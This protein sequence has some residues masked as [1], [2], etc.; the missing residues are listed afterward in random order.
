MIK[1]FFLKVFEKVFLFLLHKIIKWKYQDRP[2]FPTN[3]PFDI[4]EIFGNINKK[5]IFNQKIILPYE[6]LNFF[7]R[8][9]KNKPCEILEVDILEENRQKKIQILKGSKSV[10][11]PL[12]LINQKTTRDNEEDYVQI[13][14]GCDVQTLKLKYLNRFHY[15]PIRSNQIIN[16][17]KINSS[18]NKL[19]IGKPLIINKN[20]KSDKPKL[21]VHIFIDALTQCIIDKF[22]YKI[23]PNTKKYFNKNGTFFTNTY[24]QS[25]WT[26]SSIAGIFTGKYTNEHLIYHP[27]NKDKINNITLADVLQEEGYLTY[28]CTNIPKL[29]PINGFDKGFDRYILAAENDY[30]YIIN[31]ACEQLDTFGNYQYLFLGFFDL[32]ESHKLPPISSQTSNPLEDFQFRRLKGNSKD[33]TAL[34]DNERINFYK[35]NIIHFD[36]KLKRLYDKINRFDSNALTVLHSDHGVNFMSHT[37]ELLGKEREKVIFL[38]KNTKNHIYDHKIKEIRQLPSMI[39]ND[40][41]IKNPFQYS[42]DG[43]AITESLYPKKDYE[44]TVR[45]NKYVLFFKVSWEDVKNSNNLS[46]SPK[47]S[48]HFI[49]NEE[50]E[51]D[52]NYFNDKDYLAHLEIAKNHFTKACYNLK[53]K[54]G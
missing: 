45:D 49:K 16:S 37:E 44:I 34:Y 39:C 3:I 6:D 27:R 52:F 7:K 50:I 2:I 22:G 43:Y 18:K 25:E 9:I 38:Y 17:I 23:M 42:Y 28:A 33:T 20:L 1:R 31:E 30:N 53:Q 54:E 46:Y 19:A 10:I 29:T 11:L 12:A 14:F 21:I 13:E 32:H 48:F 8:I 51:V 41:K 36:K 40:L 5:K 35:N 24:A 4:Y 47:T 26:L 15:L